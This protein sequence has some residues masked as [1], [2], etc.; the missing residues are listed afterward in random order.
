[1]DVQY[2]FLVLLF[3]C[4]AYP[5][6]VSK[7]ILRSNLYGDINQVSVPQASFAKFESI[8]FHYVKQLHQVKY[9]KNLRL[10]TLKVFFL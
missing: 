4:S 1:M 6:H 2:K 3:G 10:T 8:F 5:S 9:S 7:K